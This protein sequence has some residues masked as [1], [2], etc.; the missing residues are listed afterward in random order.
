[1]AHFAQLDINNNVIN[2]IVISN[3]DINNE[4]FPKSE[5][6]GI[7]YLRTLYSPMSIWRQTS[8]SGSFRKRFAGIG[9]TYSPKYDAFIPP[10][11]YRSWL[12]DESTCDWVAPR[13]KPV[14]DNYYDW[15]EESLSWK[16]IE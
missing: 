8:Y 2:V 10:K 16:K 9:F 14:D 5:E 1:M 6:I 7:N 15:D 13:A 4:E 12:F 11:Y 3:D